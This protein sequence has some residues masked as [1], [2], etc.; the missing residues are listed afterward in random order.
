MFNSPV[1]DLVILLSFTYFIGS[2]MLSAIT[3]SINAGLKT[4]GKDLK[5][6]LEQMLNDPKW[7]TFVQNNIFASQHIQSLMVKNK[8]PSYIPAGNFILTLIEQ[9]KAGNYD[10]NNITAGIANSGLPDSMKRVLSDLW[11]KAQPNAV[12]AG[13]ELA[14]FEKEIETFYNNAMD[15][16]SGWYKRKIRRVS[17]IIA[18]IMA[19]ILN[20]DTIKIIK[21]SL[22]DTRKL[23]ATVDKIVENMPEIKNYQNATII[24]DG[25]SKSESISVL[26]DSAGNKTPRPVDSTNKTTAT[27]ADSLGDKTLKQGDTTT[28]K[29]PVRIDSLID[30]TVKRIKTLQIKYNNMGGYQLGYVKG[31]V[32]KELGFGLGCDGFWKF[33]VKILGFL[34]T[35]FALQL[36]SNYWFDLLNKFVNLRATGK[37]P[38]GEKK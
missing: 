28:T 18:F 19:G 14:A 35:A 37:K 23:S 20:I 24:V 2:I 17:L 31:E 13:S 15:R 12:S 27:H 7:K 29:A 38:N 4:R 8:F 22:G 26:I 3:E 5:Y 36:G 1:L 25:D 11:A 30:S 10:K 9:I 33:L 6:T 32:R 21:E 34:I 16:A